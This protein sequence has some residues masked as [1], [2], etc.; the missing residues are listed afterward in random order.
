MHKNPYLFVNENRRDKQA[1]F[2]QGCE[3]HPFIRKSGLIP[4]RTKVR[5]CSAEAHFY[6]GG[7]YLSKHRFPVTEGLLNPEPLTRKSRSG[8]F[9]R[10]ITCTTA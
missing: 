10:F 4:R 3:C 7:M 5:L 9:A 1:R 2:L 8:P 6:P